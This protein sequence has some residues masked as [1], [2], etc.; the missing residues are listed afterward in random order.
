V[1]RWFAGLLIALIVAGLSSLV[2][3]R[4][5]LASSICGDYDYA[6]Q[7]TSTSA[8][9]YNPRTGCPYQIPHYF[10][11]VG[12]NGQIFTP[13]AFPYLGGRSD[14]HSGGWIDVSFG[15]CGTCQGNWIQVGWNGGCLPRFCDSN[16]IGLYV[17]TQFT[18]NGV[19]ILSEDNDGSL[20]N[21]S[22]DI[23]SIEYYGNGN[24]EVFDHYNNLLRSY[25]NLPGS[26]LMEAGGEVCCDNSSPH[27]VQMPVQYIGYSSPGTNNTLR[28][29]GANGYVDWTP[30]L[31]TGGTAIFDESNCP[32][33]HYC[34]YPAVPYHLSI[35]NPDYYIVPNGA[36]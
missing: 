16:Q 36:N 17:E 11:W 35:G 31:S 7:L 22:A 2:P 26:G 12:I 6:I 1:R 23:Y 20:S 25:I 13:S 10:G 9:S 8:G 28:I 18:V 30:T 19:P 32:Q 27:P 15:V 5:V 21:S 24:W 14:N 33:A 29:K 4:P 3:A 34:P